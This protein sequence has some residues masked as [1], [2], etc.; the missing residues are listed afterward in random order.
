M[1]R[2]SVIMADS[3]F[4]RRIMFASLASVFR[5]WEYERWK[6]Q[7][8]REKL[9]L[10]HPIIYYYII[11]SSTG[12]R[13]SVYVC[14]TALLALFGKYIIVVTRLSAWKMLSSRACGNSL[15]C[16]VKNRVDCSKARTLQAWKAVAW[17]NKY[18]KKNN[19][20][21]I[22]YFFKRGRVNWIKC[23]I[24]NISN[25]YCCSCYETCNPISLLVGM[26]KFNW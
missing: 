14:I 22:E 9:R 18:K 26:E 12:M 5:L 10:L 24:I 15:Y 2:V 8:N 1:W 23:Y 20:F 19:Q 21:W 6:K 25:L 17:W 7:Q 3:R 4:Q 13:D 11:S 16:E